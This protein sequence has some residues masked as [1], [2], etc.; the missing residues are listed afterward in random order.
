MKRISRSVSRIL[1]VS[2]LLTASISSH[3]G[4]N[5]IGTQ[6][7]GQLSGGGSSA[8]SGLAG[9]VLNL[10]YQGKLSDK[11]AF[12]LSFQTDSGLNVYSGAYK[13]YFSGK[14]ANAPYWALGAGIYDFGGFASVTTANASIGYYMAATEN[15][16]VGFD[17]TYASAI[18]GG[19]GSLTSLG[20]NV[21]YMF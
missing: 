9:S 2:A 12:V 21:G 20:V 17:A 3:A 10:Y 1:V 13:G 18:S 6:V 5:I 4:D 15:I 8:T 16:V 19:S 14:Y 11:S 7:W